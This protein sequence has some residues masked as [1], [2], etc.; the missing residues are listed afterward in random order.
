MSKITTDRLNIKPTHQYCWSIFDRLDEQLIGKMYFKQQWFNIILKPQ[1]LHLGVA[2]E[3]SYGLMKALNKDHYKAR[4][5]IS[6][7][8]IFLQQMGFK[9][10]NNHFEVAH[11]E[12][13]CPDLYH[14]CNAELGI[15]TKQLTTPVQLTAAQLLD[16]DIDCFNRPTK[17]HPKA[18]NAWQKMKAAANNDSV[19]LKL[20]SAFRSMQY[21]TNLIKN[22]LAGGQD[23][24]HILSINTAPGHS[25]HHTGCAVDITTPEFKPLDNEFETSNAFTWLTENAQDFGFL[26]TYPK[27]NSQGIAYEP[28]H[29]CFHP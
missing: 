19:T 8:Q 15:E 11:N 18:Y 13:T 4:T 26:M 28:W 6:H 16:A 9:P 24:A 5:Q 14:S 17:L 12:L 10:L 21:Q 23:L 22:K 27:N 20:V 7:A 1:S 3:A 25:E 29:W 2:T